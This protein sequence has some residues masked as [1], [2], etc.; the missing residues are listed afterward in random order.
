MIRK[1]HRTTPT[2]LIGDASDSEFGAVAGLPRS[3]I[4]IKG[5]P[6]LPLTTVTCYQ[7]LIGDQEPSQA[8]LCGHR[9]A[10]MADYSNPDVVAAL[11]NIDPELDQV[12]R[13]TSYYKDQLT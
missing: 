11:G 2:F 3:G 5:Q 10:T 6:S 9:C 12:G 7:A 4:D 8:T 1:R 13:S